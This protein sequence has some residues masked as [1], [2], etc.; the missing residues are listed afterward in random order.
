MSAPEKPSWLVTS[1]AGFIVA[2]C[3]F[4]ASGACSTVV[5]AFHVA[6]GVTGIAVAWCRFSEWAFDR[7]SAF[8]VRVGSWII[9]RA[10]SVIASA[11]E[12]RPEP[13]APVPAFLPMPGVLRLRTGSTVYRSR[14]SRRMW[15]FFLAGDDPHAHA[16]LEAYIASA[17]R[18]GDDA[19]AAQVVEMALR[20][21][22]DTGSP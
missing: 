1:V 3:I 19:L 15:G 8:V 20:W 21:E 14:P 18:L 2:F 17:R 12:R 5:E 6:A 22:H 10:K 11:R 13:Q 9:A 7:S 4:V 16:A